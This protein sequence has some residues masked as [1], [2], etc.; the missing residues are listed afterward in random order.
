MD[1]EQKM[2]EVSVRPKQPAGKPQH[3]RASPLHRGWSRLVS[4]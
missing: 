3:C 2:N 4:R 1:S